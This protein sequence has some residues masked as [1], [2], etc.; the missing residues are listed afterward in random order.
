MVE[1]LEHAGPSRR[2]GLLAL[3]ALLLA[4]CTHAQPDDA[5]LVAFS[6][7]LRGDQQV[8]SATSMGRGQLDAVLDKDTRLF[9]WK[10]SHSGL[11]GPVT[12]AHFHGPAAPGANAPAV[13]PLM[14]PGAG[15]PERAEGAA[16]L[17][18]AQAADLMAGR[19]Y[20]NLHTA[21]FPG[22]ELRGQLV[23]R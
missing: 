19:W 8:P 18:E 1:G 17:S 10:L 2:R 23:A 9:R 7:S 15:L 16:T 12:A 6:T 14:A 3:A 11:T 5:H 13:L 22:G 20:V 4:A 21:A